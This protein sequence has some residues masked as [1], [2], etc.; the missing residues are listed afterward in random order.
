MRSHA[1]VRHLVLFALLLGCELAP[2]STPSRSTEH[3]LWNDA[4]VRPQILGGKLFSGTGDAETTARDFLA[5][6]AA[7]FHLDAPGSTL[8]LTTTREG[9]AGRYLRFAQHQRVV[10]RT[11]PVFDGEVIVLVHDTGATREVRAV[12]LELREEAATVIDAGDL[13]PAALITRALELLQVTTPFE[14]EPSATLGIHVSKAGTARLAYQVKVATETPPH[15]WTLTL[16]AATGDELARRDGVRFFEGTAYVFDMNPVASTGNTALVDGNNAT[17]PTLDAARFL[18]PLTR[19]D[20]SGNLSGTFANVRP[21]QAVRANS[22]TRDFLFSRDQLGFEQA[23]VYFHLDRTQARIQALGFTNVN[24]R[25]QEAIVDAQTSDNSFYS[26][27]NLRVNF[28]LGGVDDAEDGDIVLHEYGHSIQDNQVPNFGGTDEGAMGEGFGDYLAASFSLALAADAGRPQLSDPA[29]VGDWDGTS[30]S[31]MSPKCLRRVDGKKHYP[32][33]AEDEVHEDGEMWSAALWD[34]RGRLGGDAMDELVLEHH[35]LLA[36]NGTFFTASQALITADL[37]L[38]AGAN[39]PLLRRRLIQYGLSRT[40][41]SPAPPG[42][43]VSLPVSIGPVRDAAGNYRSGTDE[44]NTLTVPGAAGLMLHFTRVD[45]ETHNSCL[46][47]GC[48]NIYLTNG[49]GDLFQV[50]SAPQQNVTSVAIAGDTVNIRLVSDPSQVRFG[51]H[52]DR[53]E[54]LG[55]PADAGLMFD[56]GIDAFDAGVRDAGTPDAGNDPPLNDGGAAPPLLDAGVRPDA[57]VPPRDGGVVL[58]TKTLEAYGNE[59]LSP[60]LTRGCGCGVTS[61]FEGWAA[62]A[63]LGLISRRRRS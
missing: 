63:L 3:A 48:D 20:A 47:M 41:T 46:N 61:G 44:T 29:C 25:V 32:E 45:V 8:T 26:G 59:Q 49:E 37:N 14:N 22:P 4:K 60:A 27:N 6:R 15:D 56:G 10:E 31:M 33:A 2:S 51:Y 18:V 21:R 12:N 35:F 52:V 13:G 7:E 58:G 30:Y 43:T 50:L 39:G 19:L 55:A 34:L 54:V 62:L 38:N 23:N 17:T 53:V 57:G 42:P 28:G 40:L 36:G 11:L 24:N 5:S 16:D 9:K 1:P